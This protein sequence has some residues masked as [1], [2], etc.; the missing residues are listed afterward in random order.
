MNAQNKK[1][2]GCNLNCEYGY[3]IS[4]S[5]KTIYPTLNGQVITNYWPSRSCHKFIS[6]GDIRS[7][8]QAIALAQEIAQLCNHHKNKQNVK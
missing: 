5:K 3:F 4:G 7:P 2:T 1:C 8:E 6:A